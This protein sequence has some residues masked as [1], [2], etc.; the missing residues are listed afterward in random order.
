MLGWLGTGDPTELGVGMG[1]VLSPSRGAPATA[2][3][4]MRGSIVSDGCPNA[5]GSSRWKWVG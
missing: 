5:C 1:I 3:T 4:P 2:G